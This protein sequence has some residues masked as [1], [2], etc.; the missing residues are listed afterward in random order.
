MEG[1]YGPFYS[2]SNYPY[3]GYRPHDCPKCGNG[4]LEINEFSKFNCVNDYCGFKANVCPSCGEGYL[5]IVPGQNSTLISCSNYPDC[6]YKE[7][8]LSLI[9]I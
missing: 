6:S 1:R 3:C 9:H 7:E 4:F 2:C 8:L 5:H